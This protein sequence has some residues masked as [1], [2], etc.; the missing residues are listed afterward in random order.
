MTSAEDWL[1]RV[2]SSFN[3]IKNSI[4]WKIM[5]YESCSNRVQDLIAAFVYFVQFLTRKEKNKKI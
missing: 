2:K 5:K 1:M 3:Y 4:E